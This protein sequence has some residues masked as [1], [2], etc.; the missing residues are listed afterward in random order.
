MGKN[1]KKLKLKN[2]MVLK[3]SFTR[4]LSIQQGAQ[5]IIR[6]WTALK[7]YFK[8]EIKENKNN[9]DLTLNDIYEILNNPLKHAQ[10]I[11]L[12]TILSK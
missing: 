6:R 3:P 8:N 2:L 12:N 4:W 7:V 10:F 11:F 1:P 5:R 9:K